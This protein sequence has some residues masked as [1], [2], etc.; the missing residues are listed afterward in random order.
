LKT[1]DFEVFLRGLQGFL[2]LTTLL[3]SI[4]CHT[5]FGSRLHLVRHPPFTFARVCPGRL[6][7]LLPRLPVSWATDVYL[8]RGPKPM[9]VHLVFSPKLEAVA[10]FVSCTLV[11]E[12]I[13][14]P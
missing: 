4:P 12:P 1:N 11:P 2:S 3:P 14:G 10:P 5:D 8:P 13:G 6:V 7:R 9:L